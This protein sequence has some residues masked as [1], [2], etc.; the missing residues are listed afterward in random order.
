[1]KVVNRKTLLNLPTG[2]IFQSWSNVSAGDIEIFGGAFNQRPDNFQIVSAKLGDPLH[3]I[4]VMDGL[5]DLDKGKEVPA[6]FENFGRDGV[7]SDDGALFLVWDKNDVEGLVKTL[8]ESLTSAYK[9]N[10]NG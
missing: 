1:M 5:F 4:S 2:T 10:T 6:D 3:E 8:Q 9:D 7:Y